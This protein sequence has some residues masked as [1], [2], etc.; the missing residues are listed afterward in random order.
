MQQPPTEIDVPLAF[1]DLDGIDED[2]EQV[3]QRKES[4]P[5]MFG[6]K[7]GDYMN[8]NYYRKFLCPEVREVTC[9]EAKEWMTRQ[10]LLA[11]HL[12]YCKS[13]NK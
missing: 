5:N 10:E 8:C 13:I 12:E 11:D 1:A 6:Y 9:Q 4:S 3:T 2:D 7:I